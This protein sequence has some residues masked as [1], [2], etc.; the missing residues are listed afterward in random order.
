MFIDTIFLH[1]NKVFKFRPRDEWIYAVYLVIIKLNN[2][3]KQVHISLGN[4]KHY[5]T[6]IFIFQHNFRINQCIHIIIFEYFF[7]SLFSFK[8]EI[9]GF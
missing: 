7:L 5:F 3:P 1:K 8:P 9:R 6:E 4:N 2:L